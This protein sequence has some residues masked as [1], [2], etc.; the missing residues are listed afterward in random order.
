MMGVTLENY[1]VVATMSIIL[2]GVIVGEGAL[3][4]AHS[5]VSRDVGANTVVAGSPAKF[6]C[7]TGK[8]K[9]KNGND[10]PAYPWRRHFH[11]GYS[12]DVVEQWLREFAEQ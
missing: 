11:R 8:I 4:A 12:P 10:E 5:S 7:E 6:I 3:V 2:P 1:A 9:L